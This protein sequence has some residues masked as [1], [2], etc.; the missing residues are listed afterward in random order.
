MIMLET[1]RLII[2]TFKSDDWKDLYEY[3]SQ[4]EVLKYE[5]E[6]ECTI[7][8]CK[9]EALERS[10]ADYYLA[11]CLKDNG[12]MIGHVCF[13]Q[14]KPSAFLT[15]EIGYVFNPNYHGKGYATEACQCILKY[16]FVQLGAHR[17]IAKCNPENVASWRLLE[18]LSMRREAHL[19][20]CLFFRKTEEGV[21]IWWDEY[22]YGILA[23]EWRNKRN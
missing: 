18:R 2:R 8:A 15:W 7:E 4:K 1:K 12:K 10:Q 3:L 20:E 11:V 14:N 23:E 6:W 19:K 16:G 13:G 5:P 22:Q 21:A 9:E 17:I